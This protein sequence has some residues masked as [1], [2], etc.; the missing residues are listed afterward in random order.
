MMAKH[1]G[2][3]PLLGDELL[4][5][6]VLIVLLGGVGARVHVFL[7]LSIF[8]INHQQAM[9]HPNEDQGSPRKGQGGLRMKEMDKFLS[10][11]N[12]GCA[13]NYSSSSRAG[14]E[15]RT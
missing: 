11:Q 12:S 10:I 13:G 2:D 5:H 6:H 3:A 15:R 9:A 1:C 8:E 4:G 7:L 14:S